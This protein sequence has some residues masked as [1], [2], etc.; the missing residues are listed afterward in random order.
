MLEAEIRRKQ[1]EKGLLLMTHVVLGY[2][3]FDDTRRLV[4]SMVEAGA[5]L[6]ELQIPFSEPLADGPVI[7][8]ANQRALAAGSTVDRCFELASELAREYPIPFLFMTYFNIPFRR[9]VERFVGDVKAA[10]LRGVIV[11]DLPP[12]EGD[13]FYGTMNRAG[14]SPVFFFSPRSTDARLAEVAPH[15]R[16]FVYCVARTGVTGAVTEFASLDG[17]LARCRRA[18]SLPLALGFGVKSKAD[19][20]SLR[21]K[22]DIAVVGSQVIRLVDEQGVAA[23]GPFIRSLQP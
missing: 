17:Y 12:E 14:L 11:A 1:A 10:G 23:V 6:I 5:D 2:P 22:I 3:S 15:A 21:G 19:L 4:G 8:H 18:T 20:E 7:A 9:G 13:A 16:G